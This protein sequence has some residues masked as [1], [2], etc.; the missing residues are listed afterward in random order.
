MKKK[1]KAEES[2][3]RPSPLWEK[4][5]GFIHD[6]IESMVQQVLEH[7]VSEFLGRGKS[8]RRASVDGASGYRNGHGKPRKLATTAGTFTVRRPRVRGVEDRFE[9]KV[10]P[11]FKRHTERLGQLVPE[12]YLHGLAQ[13]D[14][15]LALRGLLGDAAPL[16][17]SSV[18]RLKDAWQAEFE[19]W[20]SRSLSADEAEV[21]YLW[22]DGIYVKAGLEKDKAAVLVAIGALRDGRKVVLAIEPGYREST[23]AWSAILRSLKQRGMR[24][25]RMVVGDGH[26]GIWGALV[27]VYPEAREQRCWN[28]RIVNV[29]DRVPKKLQKQAKLVLRAIPYAD[30]IEE[31]ERL[32]G[33]FRVWAEKS[34]CPKAADIL[35]TDWERLVAFYAPPK[36]H[37]K[38]LRT[39]NPVE[40]PFAAVRLRTD[41]A[42]RFKKVINATAVMWKLLLVA[43]KTF[44]RL[45]A[46]HLLVEVAAGTKYKNGLRV[47]DDEATQQAPVTTK[48][49]PASEKLAA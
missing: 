27:N 11:L 39:T 1:N 13:G 49:Q 36:E 30:T 10:L 42:K 23:E 24:A 4:L 3:S 8:E 25:P 28:H 47:R 48:T 40:S 29:L 38:H 20:S 14:F 22:V 43:E 6:R 17:A 16:S 5:E 32:R 21:I 15:E 46:P 12:L 44:R 35:E 41:A 7:E 33:K 37:W 9:S 31:A 45:D 19:S 26:L 2:T 34:G 18:A